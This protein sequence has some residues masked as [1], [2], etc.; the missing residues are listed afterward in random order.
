MISLFLNY[1][2]NIIIVG[3]DLSNRNNLKESIL[4]F[5]PI[6][7]NNEAYIIKI[8]NKYKKSEDYPKGISIN[9]HPKLIFTENEIKKISAENKE[10]LNACL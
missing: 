5:N 6:I 1:N 10:Y 7:F 3:D 8:K 4:K 9:T 2:K